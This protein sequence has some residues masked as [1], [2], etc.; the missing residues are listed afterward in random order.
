MSFARPMSKTRFCQQQVWVNLKDGLHL[1]PQSQIAQLAQRFDCDV[2]IRKD[3]RLVDAKSM[4]DL[5]TLQ[6]ACGATLY[7]EASGNDAA[8]AVQ[9]LVRLFESDFT[10]DTSGDSA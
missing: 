6:A 9:Q 4:L 5:M 7:L 1:R 10:A 2:H 3:D 8:E